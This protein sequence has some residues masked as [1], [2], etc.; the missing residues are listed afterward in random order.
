MA[1]DQKHDDPEYQARS[2][3]LRLL[4]RREHSRYELAIKLPGGA[5][6]LV[7]LEFGAP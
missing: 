2:V 3:A 1:K 6:Q 5:G 4:A 7:A